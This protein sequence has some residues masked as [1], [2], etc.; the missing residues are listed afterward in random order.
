METSNLGRELQMSDRSI[1]SAAMMFGA[2]AVGLI[3]GAAM[4]RADTTSVS[5]RGLEDYAMAQCAS[6]YHADAS[7][8]CQPVNE[9]IDSRCQEGFEAQVYPNRNGY[10]CIPAPQGY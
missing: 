9:I 4:R 3:F 8:N 5:S 10:R 7:G 1:P 2:L 6:G